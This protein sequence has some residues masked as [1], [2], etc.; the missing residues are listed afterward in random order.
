MTCNTEK[1]KIIY[2]SSEKCK[3][4]R[5]KPRVSNRGLLEEDLLERWQTL[6]SLERYH[7]TKQ[8]KCTENNLH[9]HLLSMYT[10]NNIIILNENHQLIGTTDGL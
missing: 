6:D 10:E 4:H 9:H 7:P 8:Y 1:K 2:L 3:C 5:E